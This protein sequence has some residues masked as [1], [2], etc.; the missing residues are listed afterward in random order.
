MRH[1][2][3]TSLLIL[4][5]T[6]ASLSL[7]NAQKNRVVRIGVYENP[8][9]IY[10]DDQ[11]NVRG[12]HAELIRAIADQQDWEIEFVHNTWNRLLEMT[13][14]GE[15]DIMM[16]VAYSHARAERFVFNHENVFINWASVYTRP[17]FQPQ[18]IFELEG[19]T[20]AGMENGIH[21]IGDIGIL[22][23]TREFRID[24]DMLL[25][26]DYLSAFEAVRDNEADA[27][28]VNR[29]F[30][31]TFSREYGLTRTSIIFNPVSI[32][33]AFP[34]DAEDTPYYVNAIDSTLQR[35]KDDNN[36]IY[37]QLL[38]E[39]LAGY[40]EGTETIPLWLLLTLGGITILLAIL[41]V[42]FILLKV[43]VRL[44][45]EIAK[46]LRKAKQE[47]ECANR[48]KSVFLANM[49]HEIRTPMNAIIG[50][51][52]LLQRA[53]EIT[54]EQRK[55]LEIINRSGEHL[56][57]LINEVL[58]MSRI[59]AVREGVEKN[60]F[61]LRR[62]IEQAAQ[63]LKPNADKKNI[64]ISTQYSEDFPEFIVTD[65]QKI[66]QILINLIGNAVK[67]SGPG[68]ITINGK[69]DEQD[70][71]KCVIQV[72]DS[73][74]GINEENRKRI[75]Q[76]FEQVYDSSSPRSGAGLGLAI[77]RK[78]AKLLEGDL[79]LHSSSE[80]GSTFAFSF[81]FS[82]GEKVEPH[83]SLPKKQIKSVKKE[84]LPIKILV[85]DDRDTNRDILDK[86]LR[87]LGFTLRFAVNGREAVQTAREWMPD[88]ILMDIVMP[89]INGTEAVTQ[90]RSTPNMKNIKI[91][92]LTASALET[93]KE[94]ILAAGADS[95]L[96]KPYREHQLLEELARLLS[97][98]FEYNEQAPESKTKA[99]EDIRISP[100]V[101]KKIKEQ[102]R[103]GSRHGIRDVLVTAELQGAAK[104]I[105]RDLADSYQ[106]QEIISY[107]DSLE[108]EN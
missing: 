37:Y 13:E 27:A 61:N 57:G 79:W 58:D 39:Y 41:I 3:K 36:S 34:P 80:Q 68:N 102:A 15:I 73:G 49:T 89:E 42:L 67:Y 16:D 35:M 54:D 88:C 64:N 32:R 8:P 59:E 83:D 97:I 1:K 21:T 9:K 107:L 51:S 92:A 33:Y 82:P 74:K 76:P 70:P 14:R 78:Y 72:S 81:R 96:Y 25:V 28:A 106:F 4:L 6:L 29:I 23:L 17:D 48:A 18:T 87:P 31:G 40:I 75:F 38:D 53:P 77:S 101:R 62:L 26:P 11:G 95:F 65:E 45:K 60:N 63:F 69:A 104:E 19:T 86:L 5:F 47:A 66:R 93:D 98:E 50:Y 100:Q 108:K 43:E 90:I 7:L 85:A 20:I 46:K 2:A 22:N 24:I 44:R 12:F 91:I 56:L 99:D 105:I 71:R 94:A 52:E 103:L 84:S 30:G 55:N 10:T